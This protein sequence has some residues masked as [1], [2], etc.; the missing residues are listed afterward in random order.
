[1]DLNGPNTTTNFRGTHHQH[2]EIRLI[3]YARFCEH[4][5][6]RKILLLQLFRTIFRRLVLYSLIPREE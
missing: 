2:D 1:M 3:D 4:L 5:S 6:P